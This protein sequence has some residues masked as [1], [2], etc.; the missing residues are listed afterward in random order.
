MTR[1]RV[2]KPNHRPPGW[3]KL[4][5]MRDSTIAMPKKTKKRTVLADSYKG[6]RFNAPND[7]TID[8]KG[9]IY[10]SDPRYLA[11]ILPGVRT[12][13]YEWNAVGLSAVGSFFV[14]Q[15]YDADSIDKFLE[16]LSPGDVV[17][18][19][20]AHV[21]YYSMVAARRV[22]ED[23]LLEELAG[24]QPDGQGRWQLRLWWKPYVT[25]IWLGGGLIA[26]GGLL[27]LLGR[28]WRRW[29]K[30]RAA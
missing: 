25:L 1:A 18:D 3:R 14:V 17:Y 13:V 10:F 19:I 27:A 20:G 22:G 7:M 30:E 24:N 15:A 4:S 6:K 23:L 2:E 29:R 21:G 26:L 8:T 28:A 9:R 16:V 12:F 11:K 5:G